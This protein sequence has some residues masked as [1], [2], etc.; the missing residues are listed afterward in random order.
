MDPS[1]L[2][3]S[4]QL[5]RGIGSQTAG[6]V[7]M[8]NELLGRTS[9]EFLEFN[10]E[11]LRE[12]Y[13]FTTAA[14]NRWV[15][16]RKSLCLKARELGTT[17]SKK[18]V[19][20]SCPV[21]ALYPERLEEFMATPPSLLFFYGNLRLLRS[22]TFAVQSSRKSPL[23][24]HETLEALAEEGV[25]RSEVLVAGHDT[26][27]YQRVAVVP[28]RW[29]APRI[30][31]LDMGMFAALGEDLEDEPFR[32][33]RLWRY[34][35]DPQTDLVVSAI[36]PVWTSHPAANKSRDDIIAGL[37]HRIDFGC[38]REGGN[39]DRIAR[40]A[41]TL[42]RKVRVSDLNLNASEFRRLGAELIA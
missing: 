1:E 12:E 11:V 20:I 6:R 31:V 33:A 39:M 38:I 34:K 30:L 22:K 29:G 2:A 17:L 9:L 8:R 13:K 4:L 35:F 5:C 26:P 27:E 19:R 41:L 16:E 23:A 42:N 15:A 25:E 10:A 36:N 18:G 7:L 3:L 40:R 37:A 32:L 24:F 21:D 28:L 14:A